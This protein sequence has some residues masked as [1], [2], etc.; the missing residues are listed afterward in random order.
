M[1]IFLPYI[2]ACI[3]YIVSASLPFLNLSASKQYTLASIIAIIAGSCW[4]A[5]SRSVNKE[6]VVLYGAYYDVMLTFIFLIV[7]FFFMGFSLTNRQLI[8]IIII[9]TGL[10]VT[11]T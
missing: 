9:F 8:G 4:V 7:P 5:I 10:V 1:L 6:Q 2:L 11:K 3:L